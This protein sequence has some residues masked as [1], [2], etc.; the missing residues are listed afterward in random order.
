M[1]AKASIQ[2]GDF[3]DAKNLLY[4]IANDQANLGEIFPSKFKSEKYYDFTNSNVGLALI[5]NQNEFEK[6]AER[7]GST[8]DVEDLSN[9]LTKIGFDVKIYIDLTVNQIKKQLEA[10]EFNLT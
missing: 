9:V 10:S 1:E 4:Q 8:K 5:F 7:K 3:P 6:E 2:I